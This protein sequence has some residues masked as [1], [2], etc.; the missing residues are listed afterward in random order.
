MMLRP[1]FEII[2]DI[3]HNITGSILAD[4]LAIKDICALDSA[5]C[6]KFLRAKFLYLLSSGEVVYTERPLPIDSDFHI[7]DLIRWVSAKGILMFCMEVTPK[8]PRDLFDRYTMQTANLIRQI[9]ILNFAGNFLDSLSL[10]VVTSILAERCTNNRALL[11][12]F[13]TVTPTIRHCLLSQTNL[14]LLRFEYCDE[15]SADIFS[16]G[17][18]FVNDL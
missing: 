12:R 14:K 6:N 1:L 8:L 5:F 17:N 10:D 11:C 15:V 3:P 2:T 16:H 4:W 13:S 18:I 7:P 9:S